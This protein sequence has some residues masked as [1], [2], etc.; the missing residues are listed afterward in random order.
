MA[1]RSVKNNV[2]GRGI[3]ALISDAEP[4]ETGNAGKAGKKSSGKKAAASGDEVIYID[5]NDIK[6]NKAQPRKNFEAAKISEL[7]DSI[8]EHGIIQPLIVRKSG[9]EYELVAGERRWRAARTAEVKEVPCLIRDFDDEENALIAIIENMQREDLDPIEEAEGLNEMIRAYG[10][11]QEEV[12]KSVSKSRPYITNSL[13][14]LKLPEDIRD[15]VRTGAISTGHARA[16]ITVKSKARQ[17][18]L[19]DKVV[20]DGLSVREIEKLTRGGSKAK[21]KVRKSK[22]DPDILAVEEKLKEILGTR[23][24]ITTN[25]RNGAVEIAYYSRDDLNRIIEQLES[26][27]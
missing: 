11:T 13:R 12:S 17:K 8:K 20:K 4:V 9:S 10:F 2:L 25:G 7:A 6:P 26:L 23:V 19:A 24:T 3:S 27:E 16:L 1:S 15:L 21:R 14:L 18:E 5:I 22:K